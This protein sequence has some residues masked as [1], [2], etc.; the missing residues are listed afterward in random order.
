MHSSQPHNHIVFASTGCLCDVHRIS[1]VN[2]VSHMAFVVTYS[3]AVG[4]GLALH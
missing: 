2:V 1:R 4:V 3:T